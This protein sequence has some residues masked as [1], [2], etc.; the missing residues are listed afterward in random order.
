MRAR[1]LRGL[2]TG[3][4]QRRLWLAILLN[5]TL[6]S[7]KGNALEQAVAAVEANILRTAPGLAQETF[8]IDNKKIIN[9]DGVHHEIDIFVTVEH[10]KG[11]DSAFIFECK[12]WQE[13]VGKNEIIVFSE[14]ISAARAQRG[15]FVAKSFTKDARLQ[16]SKDPRMELLVVA[17]HDPAIPVPFG[18]HTI[19]TV[20]DSIHVEFATKGSS[21][22]QAF[23]IDVS[24]ALAKLTDI[25]M[26]LSDCVLAWADECMNE[27]VNKF[28]THKLSPGI[29]ERTGECNRTFDPGKF[30]ING[31]EIQRC[32]L[33]VRFHVHVFHPAILSYFEVQSRGRVVS[34]APVTMP[35]GSSM[36]ARLVESC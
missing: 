6:Q 27:N 24:T 31:E 13:S 25:D 23:P 18:F 14:K 1:G 5:V 8:R 21:G 2:W 4:P 10:G 32:A 20:R 30:F 7:E 26:S 15:F 28:P 12:N 36:Q 35:S 29:Y 34:F 16:A 19:V 3:L 33:S 17:E 9:V 11:Y 22:T